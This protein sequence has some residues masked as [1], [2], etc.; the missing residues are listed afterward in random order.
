MGVDGRGRKNIG[1]QDRNEGNYPN[2]TLR[3]NL[4]HLGKI[5]VFSLCQYREWAFL[6]ARQDRND[7]SKLPVGITWGSGLALPI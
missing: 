2:Y 4:Q 3:L 5:L 1:E 6:C 7:F